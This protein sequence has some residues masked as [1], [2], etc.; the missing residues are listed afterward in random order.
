MGGLMHWQPHLT[1]AALCAACAVLALLGAPS[2]R[3]ALAV[4]LLL[5]AVPLRLIWRISSDNPA[6]LSGLVAPLALALPTLVA[7]F[8]HGATLLQSLGLA[9][10]VMAWEAW[11]SVLAWPIIACGRRGPTRVVV[12]LAA[13]A[14][15]LLP[16]WWPG[17]AVPL[18]AIS[19]VPQSWALGTVLEQDWL[20]APGFYE[21]AGDR[22]C[23][24]PG[25]AELRTPAAVAAVC[26][27]LGAV[28]RRCQGPFDALGGT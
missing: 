1:A 9:L 16:A 6:R 23:L 3:A 4:G 11:L 27:G 7:V 22:H 15:L 25:I 17:G 21:L 2:Q 5:C 8:V 26:L 20:R 19:F 18:A 12:V 13:G 28:A 24:M 14:A 10:V